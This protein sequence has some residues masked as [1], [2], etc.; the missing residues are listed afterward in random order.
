MQNE[1]PGWCSY[2]VARLVGS[3]EDA[4]TWTHSISSC[5]RLLLDTSPVLFTLQHFISTEVTYSQVKRYKH[6]TIHSS[7]LRLRNIFTGCGISQNNNITVLHHTRRLWIILMLQFHK[8][9]TRR[10][11]LSTFLLLLYIVPL[12]LSDLQV[13][14]VNCWTFW[15]QHR[16]HL[17][18]NMNGLAFGL[19]SWYSLLVLMLYITEFV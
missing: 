11:H 12:H 15:C 3:V 10:V 1:P 13:Y 5:D 6:T 19:W 2:S 8:H 17:S 4:V 14:V 7:D 9:I 16:T 18:E